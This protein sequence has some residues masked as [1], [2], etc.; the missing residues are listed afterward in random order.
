MRQ[1]RNNNEFIEIPARF[2][3]AFSLNPTLYTYYKLR[4][5][6]LHTFNLLTQGIVDK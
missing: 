4:Q 1:T 2:F 6:L 5:F 3:Y